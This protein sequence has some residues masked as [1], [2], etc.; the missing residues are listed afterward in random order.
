M[1]SKSPKSIALVYRPDTK[2]ALVLAKKMIAW[3]KK[4]GYKVYTGPGQK[5]LSDTVLAK[6]G[7][8][9]KLKLVIALGGDGTYL[10]AVRMLEGK[11]VPILGINLGSLGFLTPVRV[12]KALESLRKTLD[13]EMS[14]IP[15]M[16]LQVTLLRKGKKKFEGLALNDVV[17]ERGSLSQLIDIA[18][19]SEKFLI[20]Q[21]RADGLIVSSPTGSTA[22]NLASGGPIV[23]PDAR[24]FA[25]TPV[26][27]HSLNSRPLILP[28]DRRLS[29][30]LV[31]KLQKAH[32]VVDGQ[33]VADLQA[34]DEIVIRRSKFDHEMVRDPQQNYFQ[35]LREKLNFGDRV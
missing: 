21:L 27:A 35:L 9:A 28:D 11:S 31:G 26:A 22:Y 14:Q 7:D 30:K 6:K 24:V 25:V 17:L 12:E 1:T 4:N 29:I 2:A 13:N 5:K 10:R 32:F 34:G 15:R 23:H 20:N 3:L 19:F 16:M 33:K 8:L 18:L